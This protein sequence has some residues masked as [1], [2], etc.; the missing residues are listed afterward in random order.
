MPTKTTSVN[1]NTVTDLQNQIDLLPK[2]LAT[3][4]AK[5]QQFGVILGQ[6]RYRLTEVLN[7]EPS[8]RTE[9]LKELDTVFKR[10]L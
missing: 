10:A 5:T 1:P 7:L 4:R 2:H 8:T 6:M 9:I 3:E